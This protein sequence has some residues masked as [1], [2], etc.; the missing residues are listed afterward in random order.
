LSRNSI[1]GELERADQLSCEDSARALEIIRRLH[2]QS[3]GN[4]PP[5]GRRD[6]EGWRA[7]WQS[8]LSRSSFRWVIREENGELCAFVEAERVSRESPIWPYWE[9]FRDELAL[10]LPEHPL[11]HAKPGERVTVRRLAVD[12]SRQREGLAR[13][14]VECCEGSFRACSETR[15][16]SA[17]VGTTNV[18]SQALIRRL[19]GWQLD[20]VEL[21]GPVSGE[22]VL[23]AWKRFE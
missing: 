4:W 11:V 1:A 19:P 3:F 18:R 17:V 10:F 20:D 16:A 22:P 8:S 21:T 5:G 6:E 9:E 7:W 12:P 14:L 23:F 2:E 15:F 13:R